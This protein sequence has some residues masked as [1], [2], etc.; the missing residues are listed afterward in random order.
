MAQGINHLFTYDK[1]RPEYIALVHEVMHPCDQRLHFSWKF[2]NVI[3]FRIHH[4]QEL[5][6]FIS[7]VSHHCYEDEVSLTDSIQ[8]V[9][10]ILFV[11][12]VSLSR[13]P[14]HSADAS[15]QVHHC[16]LK[17]LCA[18]GKSM[19]GSLQVPNALLPLGVKCLAE[20]AVD[21]L[22]KIRV[23]DFLDNRVGPKH[24]GV[25]YLLQSI[26]RLSWPLEDTLCCVRSVFL[27]G[28]DVWKNWL[29]QS[30]STLL[31]GSSVCHEHRDLLTEGSV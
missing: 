12:P 18:A 10:S 3:V 25:Q 6:A 17:R 4:S 28:N 7:K 21:V 16:S 1:S 19:F 24:V 13:N 23:M 8:E 31:V 14:H 26:Y 9:K 2:S 27:V 20:F 22:Q 15:I 29:R 11:L 5:A 30:P